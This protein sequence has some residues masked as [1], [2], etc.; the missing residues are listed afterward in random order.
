MRLHRLYEG[1]QKSIST[2]AYSKDGRFVASG[3]L[4]RTVRV[5]N[6]SS[7][8][9]NVLVDNE[10]VFGIWGITRILFS[11]DGSLLFAATS[12][13]FIC[14]W[15]HQAASL[16]ERIKAHPDYI[17]DV[18]ITPD[19]NSI[20]TASRDK[21]LKRWDASELCSRSSCE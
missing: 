5:Y 19:G 13:G 18:S 17:H 7:D 4:D 1:H 8:E 15:D 12:A 11:P 16:L 9:C 2:V 20:M 6:T 21:T 14:I 3:S 10:P